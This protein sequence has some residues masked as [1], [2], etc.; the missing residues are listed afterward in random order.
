[1]PSGRPFSGLWCRLGGL[2]AHCFVSAGDLWAPFFATLL[3]PWLPRCV[4]SLPYSL[5]CSPSAPVAFFFPCHA[6]PPKSALEQHSNGFGTISRPPLG[7]SQYP[8]G[9]FLFHSR[10]PLA[11]NRHP[12]GR[13]LGRFFLQRGTLRAAI[14]TFGLRC[15]YLHPRSS[16]AGGSENSF[17]RSM[18]RFG[19]SG[20]LLLPPETPK[21][22]PGRSQNHTK[23]QSVD[24]H[25]S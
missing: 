3:R 20:R 11:H 21:A 5:V 14:V 17:A 24:V 7:A 13:L 23:H 1:M 12:V 25:K 9:C 2:A 6:A 10:P 15:W 19:Y 4:R 18:I 16:C 22:L 8:S